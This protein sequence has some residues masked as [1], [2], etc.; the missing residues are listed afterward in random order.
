MECLQSSK[1]DSLN[2][3]NTFALSVVVFLKKDVQ[4]RKQ[5]NYTSDKPETQKPQKKIPNAAAR[6]AGIN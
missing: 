2:P 5:W 4:T 6:T 3:M 1:K